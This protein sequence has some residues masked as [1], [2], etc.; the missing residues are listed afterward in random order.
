MMNFRAAGA[1]LI[2]L[3]AIA[4]VGAIGPTVRGSVDEPVAVTPDASVPPAV[5]TGGDSQ[6]LVYD[7]P[8]SPEPSVVRDF[9]PPAQSWAA[10]HR[11]VDLEATAGQPVSAAAAGVVA[12]EGRVVDR[13]V[14][15]IDPDD[16][17]RTTSKPVTRV[18]RVGTK[19]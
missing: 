5:E 10:G 17:I 18:V 19:G 11:G 9:E 4:L 8:L 15:S 7:W 13:P 3:G 1:G 14:A 2:A 12:F 16:G 6:A